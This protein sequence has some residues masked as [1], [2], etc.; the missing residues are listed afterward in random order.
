MCVWQLVTLKDQ[1]WYTFWIS[2]HIKGGNWHQM[3]ACYFISILKYVCPNTQFAVFKKRKINV[4]TFIDSILSLF[5]TF[6][7][8]FSYN[9]TLTFL[10]N[11][12]TNIQQIVTRCATECEFVTSKRSM[13]CSKLWCSPRP[14]TR[15][16]I[17]EEKWLL[18]YFLYFRVFWKKAKIINFYFS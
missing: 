15:K 16:N 5:T 3:S 4:I 18:W 8:L 7:H 12:V 10:T 17:T 14:N 1:K 13:L 6:W 11:F 2:V 9:R